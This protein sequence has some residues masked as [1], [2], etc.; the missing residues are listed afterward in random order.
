MFTL[1][2]SMMAFPRAQGRSDPILALSLPL[3]AKNWLSHL[4]P[5]PMPGLRLTY[6]TLRPN[7]DKTKGASSWECVRGFC[8]LVSV[9]NPTI[10]VH[11]S[12]VPDS[13]DSS[14]VVRILVHISCHLKCTA[15][16]KA[17]GNLGPERQQRR[18]SNQVCSHPDR[19][20]HK[21]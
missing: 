16:K 9:G 3:K 6:K 1:C 17:S 4:Y 20:S 13:T 11:P 21:S 19:K 18:P 12:S 15:A 7:K 10:Y 5:L 14:C 8:A 2:S